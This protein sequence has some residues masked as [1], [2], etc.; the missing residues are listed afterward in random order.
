MPRQK[1]RR[2]PDRQIS[3]EKPKLLDIPKG[4][5]G[6]MMEYIQA[7][8]KQAHDGYAKHGRGFLLYVR[9]ADD[10][11]L[12]PMIVYVY[13]GSPYWKEFVREVDVVEAVRTYDPATQFV[14]FEGEADVDTAQM[15]DIQISVCGYMVLGDEPIPAA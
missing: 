6:A 15:S 7:V 12:E 10:P 8:E 9:Y 1:G 13:T 14:L 3:G 5:Q 4:A 2:V 11:T